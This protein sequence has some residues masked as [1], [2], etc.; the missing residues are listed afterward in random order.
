MKTE[1]V[2]KFVSVRTP[3]KADREGPHFIREDEVHKDLAEEL[4]KISHEN[5]IPYNEASLML[6][7]SLVESESYYLNSQNW[8]LILPL[9]SDVENL[10]T[11]TFDEPSLNEFVTEASRLLEPVFGEASNLEQFLNNDE[12]QVLKRELWTSYYANVLNHSI[13]PE[14][15]ED[16]T[17]WIKFFHL[18]ESTA[19]EK[20]F[21]SAISLFNEM[22]PSVPITFFQ[23]EEAQPK[24]EAPPKDDPHKKRTDEIKAIRERITKLH[25]TRRFLN[26]LF[27]SKMG[28]YQGLS[29]KREVKSPSESAYQIGYLHASLS[30]LRREVEA[31]K[32][33]D[34]GE[35][36]T[37]KKDIPENMSP[38]PIRN[39]QK[40]SSPSELILKAPWRLSRKDFEGKEE[41]LDILNEINVFPETANIPEMI[42]KIEEV[43][44]RLE[45]SVSALSQQEEIVG[46]GRNFARVFR[47]HL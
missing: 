43:I 13:H 40:I 2:F 17:F 7:K 6:G 8:Q 32:A 39:P 19:S 46:V 38:Q 10:L 23:A 1:N 11:D 36:S 5:E 26:E 4:N 30:E 24:E 33:G 44:A 15:R 18:L 22:R 29:I 35:D 47:K 9:Q 41:Y 21:I 31:L 3:K 34:K 20:T 25:E 28:E 45:E 27:N 14:A 42:Y 16:L 12:Y 37:T